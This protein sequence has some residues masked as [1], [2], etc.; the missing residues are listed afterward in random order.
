MPSLTDAGWPLTSQKENI[1][2]YSS[3]DKIIQYWLLYSPETENLTLCAK[4]QQQ[5]Q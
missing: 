3:P 2:G 1:R 5:N 4:E